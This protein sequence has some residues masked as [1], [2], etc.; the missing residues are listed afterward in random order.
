LNKNFTV[1]NINLK[2]LSLD[3]K[4]YTIERANLYAQIQ[5][6]LPTTTQIVSFHPETIHI[7]YS[8]VQKKEIPV[9]IDGNLSPAAGYMF[10]DSLHIEPAKVWIYGDQKMLDT[11]QWIKTVVVNK[12]NI[13]KKLD[14]TVKLNAPEE[15]RL[16]VRKVKI[17][18]DLEEYTEKKFELPVVCRHLPENV[19]VRFFP[20]T[21]EV[22]CRLALSKYPLLNENDL[23]VE[24][25]YKDLAHRPGINVSLVLFRKPLWLTDY[26]ITPEAVEY[27]IEQKR[28]L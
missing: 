6:L 3:K 21:V 10:V 23:E 15:L 19:Q 24:V 26:R 16:S 2:N 1:F 25:D 14:L 28:E 17:S 27:L 18:A 9:L 11:L 7:W 5:S 22:T 13:Q 4:T 8:P 12:E 20:S